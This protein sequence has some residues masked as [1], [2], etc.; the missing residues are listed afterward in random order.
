MPFLTEE[1]G[2]G[3]ASAGHADDLCVA[4]WPERTAYDKGILSDIDIAEEVVTAI[5]N[6]RNDNGI[7]N[8]E[9]LERRQAGE[10][11]PVH[12]EPWLPTSPT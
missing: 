12:L 10:G 2:I 11:Y 1:C 9:K 8:K 4:A 5:R 6:I 7:P 3:R